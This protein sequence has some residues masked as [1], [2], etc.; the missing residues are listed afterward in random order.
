MQKP[1]EQEN[2]LMGFYGSWFSENEDIQTVTFGTKTA[3]PDQFFD[4]AIFGYFRW[5]QSKK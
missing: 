5:T 4:P 2:L 1:E 3:F